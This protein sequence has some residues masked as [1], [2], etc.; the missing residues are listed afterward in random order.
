MGQNHSSPPSSYVCKWAVKAA[1]RAL[2]QPF[3]EL[4][5]KILEPDIPK[6]VKVIG[7][8]LAGSRTKEI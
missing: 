6:K 4:K 7:L 8:M 5:R 3:V 2:G 1:E